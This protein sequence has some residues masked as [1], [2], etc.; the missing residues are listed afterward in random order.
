MVAQESH[1]ETFL[2]SGKNPFKRDGELACG[3]DTYVDADCAS[4]AEDR[5]S[6]SGVAGV[7]V[8]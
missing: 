6:V 7:L 8:L 2:A 4:K 3:F 1:A 5:R